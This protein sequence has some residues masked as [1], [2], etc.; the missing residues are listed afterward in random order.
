MGLG[1][2]VCHVLDDSVNYNA[3]LGTGNNGWA[4][5][6]NWGGQSCIFEVLGGIE[7]VMVVESG[8]V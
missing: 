2:R 8:K 1:S 6:C 3:I 7:K 4:I 5:E